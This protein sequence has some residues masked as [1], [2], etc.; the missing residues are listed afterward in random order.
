MTDISWP[1]EGDKAFLEGGRA[2]YIA[3]SNAGPHELG[4]LAD[5]FKTSSDILIQHLRE[6]GR[7]DALVYPI[8]FGYRQYLELR[9]KALTAVVNRSEY[10]EESF[11]RIH[12]L[13]R[14]WNTIRSRLSDEL[15]Q[16]E[17]VPSHVVE[18]VI[19]EF[20]DVDPKSDGFRFPS[21]IKQHNIDLSN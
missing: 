20:Q 15:Q 4:L 16:E 18:N 6:H 21:E 2:C 14:L 17:Q 3:T 5:G 10:S 8:I 1:Q 19:K 9:I 13:V 11:K 7:N 12:D